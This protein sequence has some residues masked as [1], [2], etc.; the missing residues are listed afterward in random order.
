MEKN[1]Q[2]HT[3]VTENL[4]SKSY[5]YKY[6]LEVNLICKNYVRRVGVI[7]HRDASQG[8]LVLL[9]ERFALLLSVT[10]IKIIKH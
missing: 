6:K 4:L 7:S 9:S 2:E 1:G 3:S 5:I 10:G 8:V